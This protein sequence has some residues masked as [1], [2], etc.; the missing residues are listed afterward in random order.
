MAL[1]NRTYGS[2][3]LNTVD[4]PCWIIDKAEPHIC[5]KLKSIFN[6]INSTAVV[7]FKFNHTPE[8]CKDMLWFID[9]YPLSI[10]DSDLKILKSGSRRYDI[11]IDELEQILLPEYHACEEYP[12]NQG[13]QARHYQSLGVDLLM[14]CNRLLIG[15]DLGLGK[16]VIAILAC[17]RRGNLPAAIVVQAHLPSQW[18]DQISKF[19]SLNV[20]YIKGTRL[21]SLPKA[22]IYIFKYSNI[23]G[24][25]DVFATG[26]FKLSVFDEVQEF[27]TGSGSKKY[28]AGKVLSS[29]TNRCLMLSATPIYNYANE[30]WNI[31]DLMSQG[32]LHSYSE[33]L[34]EWASG[35]AGNNRIVCKDPAA[36]GSYL[37]QNFLFLRRTRAEVGLELPPV[38]KIVHTI[39]YD[40]KLMEKDIELAKTLAI[41]AMTGSFVESG[42]ASRKLNAL[43]R[44]S[45]GVSKAPFVAE[46]VK[47]L[48][49]NNI[50][51]I[52]AG[53]HR[54]VY[55][56][57]AEL[58]AEYNP[59]FYTGTE[60]PSKK[61][62][63]FNAFRSGKTNLFIISLRSGAGL[64]G[65]QDCC[66]YIVFGEL[67]YSP[68]IHDQVIGRIHRPGQD[69]QVTA[70]FLTSNEG[71]DPT[72]IS[73][74]GLKSSQAH[75][76]TDPFTDPSDQYSDM[77]NI[78]QLASD[79][80][81]KKGIK[82]PV[83]C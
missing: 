81:E 83:K 59:V 11:K 79:F 20:H 66:H 10:S 35:F 60:S 70:V 76:I 65:L 16:T 40:E 22:D 80:L 82:V 21:Y 44:H 62:E 41:Q 15:D 63:A 18:I 56:I 68:K 8:V 48:L 54:E 32:C 50:P 71:S 45:T 25:V 64:D 47:M 37:R 30:I 19:T 14:K 28:D 12:L 69:E 13:M 5:I 6:S 67:D 1:K 38:N 34:R 52:L 26:F 78:R 43:L 33:F 27:R 74:L 49:D 42:D 7:P 36:L 9:R 58:L 24:W 53:W 39:D 72:M 4:K 31:M 61:N 2:I 57:W 29:N 73:L 55:S 46:Y 77:S 3:H 17:L 23:S 51:V 75:Y